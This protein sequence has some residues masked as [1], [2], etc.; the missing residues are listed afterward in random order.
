[1][2]LLRIVVYILLGLLAIIAMVSYI[3]IKLHKGWEMFVDIRI[4]DPL[5]DNQ[6]I[7]RKLSEKEELGFAKQIARKFRISLTLAHEAIVQSRRGN[8]KWFKQ[9]NKLDLWRQSKDLS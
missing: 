2:E 6:N 9:F 3:H 7:K 4:Y 5:Y 1:M 8:S